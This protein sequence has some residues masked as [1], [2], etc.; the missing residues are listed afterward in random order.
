MKNRCRWA[1]EEEGEPSRGSWTGLGK[2]GAWCP[3]SCGGGG[4]AGG[5]G[6]GGGGEHAGPGQTAGSARTPDWEFS[7]PN[8]QLCGA[9]R[10]GEHSLK[11]L[12]P[13]VIQV[14]TRLT[15][16]FRHVTIIW[17]NRPDYPVVGS[18]VLLKLR[19]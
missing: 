17:L 9:L 8:A 11:I 6:G 10:L 5:G 12:N 15:D 14:K 4:G 18:R 19:S 1:G 2:G 3:V 16:V 13:Y 7:A